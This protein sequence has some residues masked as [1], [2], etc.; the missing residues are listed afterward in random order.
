V[1]EPGAGLRG[2]RVL[3]TGHTG[4]KGAWLTLWLQELGAQVSGLALAP[5]HP[6]LFALTDLQD[7]LQHHI[8]GDVRDIDCVD[9]AFRKAAPEVVFHLAAQA[10]VRQGQREPVATFS[11]NILGT[12]HVLDAVRRLGHTRAVVVV[13]TDKCYAN[14]GDRPLQETDRLGGHGPYSASKAAA[15]LVTASYRDSY[16]RP[17]QGVF[18]ATARAGNVLG[19]GDWGADRLV[20][21]LVR[22]RQCG[23]PC[24]V[25]S[26]DSVR[27]WQH[28]LEPL[29]GYLMLAEALLDANVSAATA[30]NFGPPDQGRLT[31]R[32]L[33]TAFDAEWDGGKGPSSH[34]VD[35]QSKGPTESAVLR[36][37]SDKA[38]RLLGWTPRLS[39]SD[40]IRWTARWYRD[41]LSAKSTTP[42]D[43]AER[44]RADLRAWQAAFPSP[45]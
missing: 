19:G 10:L 28:V 36:L 26:P 15:E 1:V 23:E 12:V 40:A 11:T 41:H 8:V 14:P 33:A 31:V 18:V 42:S 45:S 22:A 24:M 37:S 7:G 4:F 39:A 3:V 38:H 30:F 25:R 32:Q 2:R 20:P 13:T 29:S 21:D 16:F 9:R 27:P 35:P 17:D 5:E 44:C 34:A 6:S 43:T